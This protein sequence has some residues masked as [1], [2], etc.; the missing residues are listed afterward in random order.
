MPLA[1]CLGKTPKRSHVI[2]QS[3]RV[4]K[5]A[6]TTLWSCDAFT[7][8]LQ[9]CPS[10]V[11]Q[12][13]QNRLVDVFKHWLYV[14]LLGRVVWVLVFSNII[15]VFLFNS[16]L[17]VTRIPSSGAGEGK[18][19]YLWVWKS[20]W[21][22]TLGFIFRIVSRSTQHSRSVIFKQQVHFITYSESTW[23]DLRNGN[24]LHTVYV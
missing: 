10:F 5:G 17:W 18:V 20:W 6:F 16:N 22:I 8:I 9:K 24:P 13:L 4:G 15:N 11:G 2:W 21:S 3:G 12:F 7:C 23:K 14:G 19:S 1:C